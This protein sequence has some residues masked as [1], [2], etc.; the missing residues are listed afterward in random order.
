MATYPSNYVE[1]SGYGLTAYIIPPASGDEPKDVTSFH[2][3]QAELSEGNLFPVMATIERPK[4]V[5]YT[6]KLL[7][8]EQGNAVIGI[9]GGPLR[10]LPTL[11][12]Y[13]SSRVEGWRLTYWFTIDPRIRYADIV[14]RMHYRSWD[15]PRTAADRAKGN[16]P[17]GE[18]P[19]YAGRRNFER[20]LAKRVGQFRTSNGL[21]PPSHG[22][23]SAI[24]NP[25]MEAI[26]RLSMTQLEYGVWWNVDEREGIMWQPQPK[27][28]NTFWAGERY[29][30]PE[31]PGMS[32]RVKAIFDKIQMLNAFA[33]R[34]R[35]GSWKDLTAKE[36]GEF[37][38]RRNEK[39]LND[40]ELAKGIEVELSGMRK[41]VEQVPQVRQ[42]KKRGA[43]NVSE[44]GGP[45]KQAG[46]EISPKRSNVRNGQKPVEVS[47]ISMPTTPTPIGKNT[48]LDPQMQWTRMSKGTQEQW[49]AQL[50]PT[51]G[52]TVSQLNPEPTPTSFSRLPPVGYGARR[53]REASLKF[54]KS[55]SNLPPPSPLPAFRYPT[56]SSMGGELQAPFSPE[57]SSFTP[58]TGFTSPAGTDLLETQLSAPDESLMLETTY[59]SPVKTDPHFHLDPDWSA[60]LDDPAS[61][62]FGDDFLFAKAF[63][64]DS[65]GLEQF[66]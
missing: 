26:S 29:K 3:K 17:G 64:N 65:S 42:G 27:D 24:S 56:P 54:N 55:I 28:S 60:L 19:L 16:G 48:Q 20:Q 52:A 22:G 58:E 45:K 59:K 18:G 5:N 12:R 62:N 44:A 53:Q 31:K 30:L 37:D 43:A 25:D 32:S 2:P 8:D 11:P 21:L 6:N 51:P 46:R 39:G 4:Q 50:L 14:E 9:N 35:K 57:M 10:D 61:G 66:H 38:G 40:L 7:Y 23:A 1:P 41:G 63:G 34:K 47:R 36:K 13:I 15:T 49:L 33:L